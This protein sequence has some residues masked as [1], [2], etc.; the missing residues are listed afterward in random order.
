MAGNRHLRFTDGVAPILYR[1]RSGLRARRG[2]AIGLAVIVAVVGGLVL[3]LVAGALRT[4][5]A[6]SRYAARQSSYDALVE[7]SSGPPLTET[8][9]GLPIVTRIDLASFV[10]GGLL[11]PGGDEQL[12]TLVFAGSL[13]ALGDRLVDGRVPN[14]SAPGE[15]V[16]TKSFVKAA[17]AALGDEFTLITITQEQADESGFDVA[18][19]GGPTLAATLVGVIDGPAELQDDYALTAFPATL[20]DQGDV[21][22]AAS[23]GAIDLEPGA[24][25]DDLRAQI[26]A[27]PGGSS[28]GI[29]PWTLFSSDVRSAVNTQGQGLAVVAAIVALAAV[30]VLGQLLSRQLRH[31][32]AQH[33]ALRALGLSHRQLVVDQLSQAAAPLAAGAA[34][35]AMLAVAASG[36]FPVG[37]VRAK[38]EPDPGPLLD[39]LAHILGPLLFALLVVGWLFVTLRPPEHD[40]EVPRQPG[41]VD[42]LAHSVR[43]LSVA[44]GLRFALARPP[45]SSA[46][47][48]TPI[49][50][51][52]LVLTILIGALTF[53]ANIDRLIEEP[54][55]WGNNF[56]VG[57]GQGGDVVPEEL[58]AA[59]ANDPDVAD[60]SSAGTVLAQVGSRPLDITGLDPLVGDFQP[61]LTAGRLPTGDGEIV[62]GR[63]DARVLGVGVDDEVTI[64]GEEGSVVFRVVGL[65]V[66]PSVEGGDGLGKGG[67]VTLAGLHRIDSSATLG[68]LVIRYRPDAP[69]GTTERL[70]EVTGTVLGLP[71]RPGIILNL[72]RVRS[73]P[74]LV[75]GALAVLALLSLAH[76]LLVSARRRRRDIA[77]LRALGADRR[78]VRSAMHWQATVFSLV[79]LVPAMPIGFAA[80]GVLYRSLADRI[81]TP[82]DTALPLGMV[83]LT[84]VALVVLGNGVA[85]IPARRAGR[86]RPADVLAGE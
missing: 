30:A 11:R 22:I 50:G 28:V 78:W 40:D 81:G 21:G 60:I 36:L 39:P 33:E 45:S 59:L 75:A 52:V 27:L 68:T 55:R 61:A 54:A 46:S 56:D 24:T 71:D 73:N 10:F 18:E 32:P 66:I 15:F 51:L 26:D 53:G 84:L 72:S 25:L 20:L 57:T 42:R 6:P 1:L 23:V 77:V 3:T 5:S 79:V 82:A 13:A 14:P 38:A 41:L 85:M 47:T 34:L 4:L 8:L 70:A 12:D 2:T 80:G 44:T 9:L 74:Y 37:F 7:Q 49:I 63:V 29:Q 19:P 67:V 58:L 69:A 86:E 65:G 76:Q 35:A 62:L 43:P 16:A 83:G 48:R 31:T 64:D 17:K